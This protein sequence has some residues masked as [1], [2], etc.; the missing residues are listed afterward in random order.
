MGPPAWVGAGDG[1]PA[2]AAVSEYTRWIGSPCSGGAM[3]SLCLVPGRTISASSG[4]ADPEG[5]LACTPNWGARAS[6]VAAPIPANSPRQVARRRILR[7]RIAQARKPNSVVWCIASSRWG[8][9]NAAQAA[10]I[11]RTRSIGHGDAM[12]IN[13][14]SRIANGARAAWLTAPLR[15]C[16]ELGRPLV[17]Q[18]PTS[19]TGKDLTPPWPSNARSRSSSRTQPSV[20]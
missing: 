3:R 15:R 10:P 12:T 18:P 9:D 11:R 13:R 2:C 19:T 1:L 14:S 16:L 7:C 17:Y 8:M 20:T 6:S 4:N 5:K